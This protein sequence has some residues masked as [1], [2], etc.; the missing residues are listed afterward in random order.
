MNRV[1]QLW[2]VRNKGEELTAQTCIRISEVPQ[3]YTP[4]CTKNL[5]QLGLNRVG[6]TI[7]LTTET[8]IAKYR[9]D[10]VSSREDRR[11][12]FWYPQFCYRLY[13][14]QRKYFHILQ[15]WWSWFMYTMCCPDEISRGAWRENKCLAHSR[16]AC[17]VVWSRALFAM[18]RLT[19]EHIIIR[20]WRQKLQ[21]LCWLHYLRWR[22]VIRVHM[23]QRWVCVRAE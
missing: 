13:S 2:N 9:E 12:V 15:C 18:A 1:M 5:K 16:I 4:A 8:V 3:C 22:W 14:R 23:T 7:M 21:S 17:S 20:R 10:T 19:R 11:H 6:L